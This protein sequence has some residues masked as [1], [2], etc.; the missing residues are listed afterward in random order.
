[1]GISATAQRRLRMRTIPPVLT[2]AILFF[3]AWYYIWGP[4]MT[5]GVRLAA[6]LK[7]NNLNGAN[8]RSFRLEWVIPKPLTWEQP[9]WLCK[10]ARDPA[11]P[12]VDFGWWVNPF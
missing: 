2:A 3:A 6:E 1:M 9:H 8:Y 7:C 11:K 4:S 5:P 10:D 12:G